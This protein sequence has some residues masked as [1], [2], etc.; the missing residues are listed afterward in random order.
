MIIVRVKLHCQPGQTEN[1][2]AACERM[3]AASR[4]LPGV[5]HFDVARDLTDSN[6]L[7]ATEI[8]Q[9]REALERQESLA[10]VASVVGLI[11]GGA[12]TGAPEWTQYEVASS[13]SPSL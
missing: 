8:Y 2:V 13:H 4:P 1:V 7:I 12:L 6:A 3:V 5:I 11:R 10:E 9:D